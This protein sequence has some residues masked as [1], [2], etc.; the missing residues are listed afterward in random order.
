MASRR[1]LVEALKKS[2][3]IDEECIVGV[4]QVNRAINLGKN[5]AIGVLERFDG[6]NTALN[7]VSKWLLL[8]R[9]KGRHTRELC[10]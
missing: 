2:C 1:D 8:L 7:K 9:R 6:S 3:S 4:A 10:H 5:G